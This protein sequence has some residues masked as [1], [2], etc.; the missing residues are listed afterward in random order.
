MSPRLHS[1]DGPWEPETASHPL[2]RS[3]RLSG[4]GQECLAAIGVGFLHAPHLLCDLPN[5]SLNKQVCVILLVPHL[6][7]VAIFLAIFLARR[8]VAGSPPTRRTPGTVSLLLCLFLGQSPRHVYRHASHMQHQ[9]RRSVRKRFVV[10]ASWRIGLLDVILV[11]AQVRNAAFQ[12]PKLL[13]R[14]L[15]PRSIPHTAVALASYRKSPTRPRAFQL[16]AYPRL[17]PPADSSAMTA[18]L[19]QVTASLPPPSK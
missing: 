18:T 8:R 16:Q 7:S 4:S 2:S 10:V 15:Q 6:A 14:S 19:V 13:T 9:T 5:L 12:V 3:I 1:S 11:Y 17:H